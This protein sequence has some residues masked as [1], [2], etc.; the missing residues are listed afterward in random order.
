MRTNPCDD[1][2]ATLLRMHG[3]AS[4]TVHCGA[5]SSSRCVSVLL[6]FCVCGAAGLRGLARAAGEPCV[7]EIEHVY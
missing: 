6:L 7:I 1:R 3:H 4:D 2:G 5:R